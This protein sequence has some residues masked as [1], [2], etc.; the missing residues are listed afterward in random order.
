MSHKKFAE[1]LLSHDDNAFENKVEDENGR[2]TTVGRRM[3][4]QTAPVRGRRPKFK[5]GK[6]E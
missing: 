5:L 6:I 1:D 3:R 2:W 4:Q